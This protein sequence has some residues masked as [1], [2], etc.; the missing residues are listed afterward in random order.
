MEKF[1]DWFENQDHDKF[2]NIYNKIKDKYWI[3]K[4]SNRS[5]PVNWKY[6]IKPVEEYRNPTYEG[7]MMRQFL[8]EIKQ[9]P[10]GR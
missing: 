2:V 7:M 1:E 4:Y 5:D 9:L 10:L 3:L 6:S 8:F